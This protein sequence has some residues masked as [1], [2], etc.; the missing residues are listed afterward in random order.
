VSTS[1]KPT[2]FISYSHKDESWKDRFV[3]QL[4]AL[5]QA[6][7]I[8]VWDDRK[9]DGGDIATRGGMR[10]VQ[11]DSHLEYA[12]LYV[13]QGEKEKGNEHWRTAREMIEH[14]GYHRRDKD[15]QEIETQLAKM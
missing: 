4:R 10:L 14:I 3:P 6:G 12:R 13:M 9:I 11:A 8:V 5:E 2:V 1:T 15:V 7:R